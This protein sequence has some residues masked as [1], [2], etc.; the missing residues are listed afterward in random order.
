MAVLDVRNI[1]THDIFRRNLI[2]YI[3]KAESNDS[4]L[5]KGRPIWL[6]VRTL[7]IEATGGSPTAL[8]LIEVQFE[9]TSA[10]AKISE[11][12]VAIPAG[13]KIVYIGLLD[14]ADSGDSRILVDINLQKELN[15][16]TEFPE[17]GLLFI[18]LL[19]VSTVLQLT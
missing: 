17:A 15:E 13:K 9:A 7:P 5:P 12:T 18:E 8:P 11:Y 6:E 4:V 14:E 16:Q 19:T 1:I 2:S 3:L 10:G